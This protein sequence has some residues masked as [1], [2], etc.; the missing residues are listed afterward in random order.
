MGNDIDDSLLKFFD[1]TSVQQLEVVPGMT[2]RTTAIDVS[3]AFVTNNGSD[4]SVFKYGDDIRLKDIDSNGNSRTA[5]WQSGWISVSKASSSIEFELKLKDSTF[6]WKLLDESGQVQA[7]ETLGNNNGTQTVSIDG[8]DQGYYY[9]VL[10][11]DASEKHR[12]TYADVGDI[13]VVHET[14]ALAGQAQIASTPDELGLALQTG[15]TENVIADMGGDTLSGGR[16]SDILF[17]DSINTDNLPWGVDGNPAKPSDLG[18]GAGMEGLKQF[19]ELKNGTSPSDSELYDYI[20]ANHE[21]LNVDGDT[22]GG[23]DTLD[24]GEGDDILYGQGGTDTLIGGLGNDILTGGED[25]DIFKFVDQGTG[26]RDGEVD[27][28]KDFTAH[29]DKIDISELL[30]T[31]ANDSITTLLDN[32][33]IGLALNGDNLELTISDGAKSQT[34]IIEGGKAEYTEELAGGPLD[35]ASTTAILNDLLKVY[36]TTNH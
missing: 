27:T 8:L 23:N 4:G 32:H 17:G 24:G 36:D 10:Q 25:A 19:L 31:D 11:H 26:V 3:N 7:R 34:V 15:Q 22:R 1:N 20:K 9:L 28:I 33:E 21:S 16:D 6:T 14:Y 5:D 29:E 12:N 13:K 35:S 30:H 18:E 2:T